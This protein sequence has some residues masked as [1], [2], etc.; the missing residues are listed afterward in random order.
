MY[1]AIALIWIVMPAYLVVNSSLSSDI[2][3]GTC[4]PWGTFSSYA[5]EKALT[6]SL[7]IVT[8]MVP[9]ATMIFCYIRIVYSIRTRVRPIL[10]NE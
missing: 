6:S 2:V 1:G 9:I 10:L 5:A 7:L 8:Y 3:K 4:V